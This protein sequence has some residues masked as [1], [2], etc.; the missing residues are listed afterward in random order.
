MTVEDDLFEFF[1]TSTSLIEADPSGNNVDSQRVI[2]KMIL[3][4]YYIPT[5][6]S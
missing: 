6:N 4:D 2:R 1:E 3:E 5:H